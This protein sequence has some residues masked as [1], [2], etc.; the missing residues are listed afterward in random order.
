MN[1]K[2]YSTRLIEDVM[3]GRATE[4]LFRFQEFDMVGSP[5][6]LVDGSHRN[7][8]PARGTD[9]TIRATSDT[10]ESRCCSAVRPSRTGCNV[11]ND[12]ERPRRRRGK[13]GTC[14][15][16]AR[17]G[18]VRWPCWPCATPGRPCV[19]MLAVVT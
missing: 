4:R 2:G 19:R 10:N 7:R 17:S 5:P 8:P 16:S 15:Q 13:A 1:A 9:L 11:R 6:G 3:A 12:G 18:M 14:C